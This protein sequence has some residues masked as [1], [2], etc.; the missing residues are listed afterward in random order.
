VT[1]R[2]PNGN[3]YPS[4]ELYTGVHWDV[5][6]CAYDYDGMLMMEMFRPYPATIAALIG[7]MKTMDRA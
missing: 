7:F 5:L 6:D 1:F 4:H 2:L 3:K